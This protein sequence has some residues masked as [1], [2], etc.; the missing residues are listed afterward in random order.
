VPNERRSERDMKI[1]DDKSIKQV[2][3]PE[4]QKTAGCTGDDFKNILSDAQSK[5]EESRD[6]QPL[7][8]DTLEKPHPNLQS[9]SALDRLQAG[10][11]NTALA[12]NEGSKIHKV[13]QLLDLLESYS[14]A[15]SDPK[16]NLREVSSLVRLLEREQNNLEELGKN[17]ADGDMLQDIVMQAVI[18][19]Q[20]EVS[21]FNRGDY[22]E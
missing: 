22:L 20:V 3:K 15:L 6:K 8:I 1:Q 5:I 13:E 19:S 2:L 12:R 11:F 14:E 21:R 9:A 7:R 17:L 10:T 18:L 16:K 4:A